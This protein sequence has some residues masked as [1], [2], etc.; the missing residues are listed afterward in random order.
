MVL[1]RYRPK[2]PHCHGYFLGGRQGDHI[3]NVL[4]RRL[5]DDADA[6]GMPVYLETQAPRTTKLY[7]RIGFKM[8]ED[9]IET[10]PGGPLT[11]TM[12]RE[13]RLRSANGS[14]DGLKP[15]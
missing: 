7:A 1:N 13:P 14:G 12:W 5:F 4:I 3:G 2:R 11:W 8:L 6:L 10:I 9:G 15:A